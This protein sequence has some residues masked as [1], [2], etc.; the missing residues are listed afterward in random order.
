M[1]FIDNLYLINK[2]LAMCINEVVYCYV[3]GFAY[4]W[5]PNISLCDV[6]LILDVNSRND[7]NLKYLCLKC[8]VYKRYTV[9]I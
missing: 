5:L 2:G 3:I 4:W 8:V 9:W 7:F 1:V 6:I